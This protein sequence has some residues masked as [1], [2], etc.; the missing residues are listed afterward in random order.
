M[1]HTILTLTDDISPPNSPEYKHRFFFISFDYHLFTSRPFSPFSQATSLR[2]F[3]LVQKVPEGRFRIM[4]REHRSTK[5]FLRHVLV[6]SPK[7]S[8]HIAGRA[9]NSKWPYCVFFPLLREIRTS[10][11]NC[12][13]MCGFMLFW[14]GVINVEFALREQ[15]NI[16]LWGCSEIFGSLCS[17]EFGS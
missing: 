16:F 11:L 13:I 5:V 2:V 6:N 1:S 8:F 14:N 15:E 12:F 17:L 7:V 3:I 4:E 10:V 9:L